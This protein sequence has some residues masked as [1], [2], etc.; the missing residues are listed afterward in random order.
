MDRRYTFYYY[1]IVISVLVIGAAGLWAM[2]QVANP[3]T[4][5]A[6]S[7]WAFITGLGEGLGSVEDDPRI[8]QI[9]QTSQVESFA[10]A[11]DFKEYLEEA[12]SLY[13]GSLGFVMNTRAISALA[14]DSAVDFGVPMLA[15]SSAGIGAGGGQQVDR[16]STTNVQVQGIDEPDIL[17]TDGR[18]NYLPLYSQASPYAAKTGWLYSKSSYW[19]A[20]TLSADRRIQ[21][22]YSGRDF[23]GYA[24]RGSSL[25]LHDELLCYCSFAGSSAWCSLRRIRRRLFVFPL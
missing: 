6:Q 3:Y 4:Q 7:P 1:F 21:R 24:S 2:L 14:I 25:P 17:K 9:S 5:P 20:Q 16:F 18:E 13:G 19:R 23:S 22:R 10:S 12:E 8:Q 15:E 11:V